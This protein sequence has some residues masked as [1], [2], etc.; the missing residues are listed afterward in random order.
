AVRGQHET[1]RCLL[2]HGANAAGSGG[3]LPLLHFEVA[4][5]LLENGSDANYKTNWVITLLHCAAS[6]GNCEL[7]ELLVTH[8][9]NT[10]TTNSDRQT[11]LAL[12][13]VRRRNQAAIA[14]LEKDVDALGM[15]PLHLAVNV[16]NTELAK[17]LLARGADPL[18]QH[19]ET[20][21]TS[22]HLSANQNRAEIAQ[23]LENGVPVKK[24]DFRGRTAIQLALG[25]SSTEVFQVLLELI[26]DVNAAMTATGQSLLHETS[27]Q[28][29]PSIVQV[30]LANPDFDI[31]RRDGFGWTPLFH[32]ARNGHALNSFPLSK[33]ASSTYKDQCGLM[34]IFAAVRNG[35]GDATS[36]LLKATPAS[37]QQSDGFG[38]TLF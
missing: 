26:A 27:N 13:F 32:A 33:E 9:A 5:L 2:Q 11:P 29:R 20:G 28:G 3:K 7:I 1:V 15:T 18:T 4:K 21:R 31:D 34:P 19:L 25:N 24:T 22:L 17:G 12:A 35:L 38:H 10:S 23:L 36:V 8:G 16:G 37:F 14:L 30:L 6:D